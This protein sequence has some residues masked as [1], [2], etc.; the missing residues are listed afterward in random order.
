ML[1]GNL[2][3]TSR[4]EFLASKDFQS[5][6]AV[7][8]ADALV[9]AGT[10]ITASGTVASDESETYGLLMYDVDPAVNPNGALLVRGIV[11][12]VMARE[13]SGATLNKAA[14]EAAV[15][16]LRLR[17][18]APLRY[19]NAFPKP[20]IDEDTLPIVGTGKVGKAVLGETA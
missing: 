14:I 3:N 12:A 7:I 16:G 17:E 2:G 19:T 11:N 9:K 18:D 20:E 4:V 10:P 15:P 5:V 1:F 6:P 13:Y 8:S